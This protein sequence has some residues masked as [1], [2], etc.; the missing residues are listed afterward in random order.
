MLEAILGA[1]APSIAAVL[2][3]ALEERTLTAAEVVPLFDV[4]GRDLLA[5]QQ[6]ADTLR[7]QQVGDAVTYV[8]NRNINFTNVC[9][10]TCHFCAFSREL[11]SEQGY[12]LPI[13]EIVTR[14]R[15]AYEVGATEVCLQAGLL[16]TADGGL[17]GEI[18]GAVRDALP[19]LHLH[20]L[21]PEE[22]RYGSLR[23]KVPVREFLASMKEAGLGSLPGTSAEILDDRIRDRI[24]P[25]R[26]TTAQW[27]EVVTTAHSLG[28]PTTSTMM[29][30]HVE[31]AQDR[32]NHMALLRSIQEDTGGFTEFVPLSFVHAESPLFVRRHLEGRSDVSAGPTGNDIV[33]LYAIARLMLGASIR[34]IQASWVKEGARMSQRLL[35]WGVND[36]G[37]TLINESIS[38]SA[39]ASH[40]QLM[41]P[42]DLRRLIDGAGRSARQ[43][44]TLY[45]DVADSG[46]TT[47]LLD[48]VDEAGAQ[49][50]GSYAELVANDQFRYTFDAEAVR[51]NTKHAGQ[52]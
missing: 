37:G 23:A 20:A 15:Q 22:V 5:L 29:F 31:S 7:H 48:S 30:G 43:R 28:I 51:R 14:A 27:I 41:R 47:D 39:G 10:K 3:R 49:A 17:Y 1:A 42:S 9:V 6:V 50:F 45:G 13:D 16:P 32:A 21:S 26:I 44:T 12:L 25:G 40:G 11:R 34:N 4:V 33:R 8:V 24:S 38:T 36:L 19:T 46:A 35:D 2:E 52:S 18:L